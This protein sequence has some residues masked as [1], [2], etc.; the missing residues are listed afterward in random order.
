MKKYMVV[1]ATKYESEYGETI[2]DGS[3]S[4]IFD[5]FHSAEQHALFDVMASYLKGEA[6]INGLRFYYE[7]GNRIGDHNILT[8]L[9]GGMKCVVD[10]H[11]EHMNIN[12]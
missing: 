6:V 4:G 1:V 2:E 12:D 11:M 7:Y 8:G 10:I 3:I 5:D 9:L